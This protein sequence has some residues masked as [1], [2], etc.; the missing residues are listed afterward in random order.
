MFVQV[1][2]DQLEAQ[3][4]SD[5]TGFSVLKV[6]ELRRIYRAACKRTPGLAMHA[7]QKVSATILYAWGV[8]CDLCILRVV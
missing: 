6:K 2:K 4:I 3:A 5:Q 7:F 8:L 1:D